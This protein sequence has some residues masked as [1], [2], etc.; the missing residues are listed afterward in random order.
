MKVIVA[1]P[2]QQHSFKTAAAVKKAGY[3]DKYIT[4]VYK[5]ENSLTSKIIKFLKGD[6]LT[7]ANSRRSEELEDKEVI[8]FCELE[9]LILLLLQRIDKSGTIHSIW[10]Q[11]I[12]WAFNKKIAGYAIKNNI[13]AVI[14]YDVLSA[15]ALKLLKK[16]APNIKRIIDMSAPNFLYMDKIFNEDLKKNNDPD[17]YILKNEIGSITYKNTIK[18]AKLELGLADYFLVASSFSERSLLDYGINEKQIFKCPYGIDQK[19]KNREI[20]INIENRKLNCIFVGRITQQKG[21]FYLFRAISQAEKDEISFKFIGSYNEKSNYYKHFKETCDFVGH[22]P[23]EQMTEIYQVADVL[24]FPSLADGFGLSVIEALSF[25][26]PVI[27]SE[28][29]G[30]SDLVIDGYNGFVIPTGNEDEIIKKL[31][32][33]NSNRNRIQEMS[34]N[35]RK[36]VLKSTWETYDQCISNMIHSIKSYD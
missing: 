34:F 15:S 23:K 26:V 10:N 30:A 31:R 6:N 24:V 33:F 20:N 25:G 12:N 1:H 16:K 21:A 18:N 27:C 13:D 8:Q 4:T 32:W 3:L 5:K 35:A 14:L 7:R 28:N 22:V 36:S 2:A 11:Y 19:Y 29:A 17:S 9:S